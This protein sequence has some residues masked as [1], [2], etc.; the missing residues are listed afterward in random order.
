M[1]EMKKKLIKDVKLGK[2][3]WKSVQKVLKENIGITNGEMIKR[4][5]YIMPKF[6]QKL[7]KTKRKIRNYEISER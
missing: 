1:S 4:L 2:C 5:T 3:M 6:C 7:F